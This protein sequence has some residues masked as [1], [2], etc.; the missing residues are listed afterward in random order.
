MIYMISLE[1]IQKKKWIRFNF[2][3]E[4][5]QLRIVTNANELKNNFNSKTKMNDEKRK[6]QVKK[7]TKNKKTTNEK[8]A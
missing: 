4:S 3:A 2:I 8:R 7:K 1:I 6:T 5:S